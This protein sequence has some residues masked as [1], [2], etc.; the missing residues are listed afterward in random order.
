MATDWDAAVADMGALQN[1]RVQ[2]CSCSNS[3]LYWLLTAAI[4]QIIDSENKNTTI[5]DI[6]R[7]LFHARET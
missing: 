1:M 2:R 3:T 5:E 4:N 7:A 6:E